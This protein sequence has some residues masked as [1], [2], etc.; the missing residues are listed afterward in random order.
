MIKY[1]V[2]SSESYKQMFHSVNH[3]TDAFTRSNANN[4]TNIRNHEQRRRKRLN[5]EDG[6]ASVM[7]T[8]LQDRQV[9]SALT[10]PV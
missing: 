5:V 9:M 8:R 3:D 2:D 4:L 7:F 6:E 10:C 1:E